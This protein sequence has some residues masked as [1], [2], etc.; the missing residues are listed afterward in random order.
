M[1]DGSKPP[2]NKRKRDNGKDTLWI[3]DDTLPTDSSEDTKK[4]TILLNIHISGKSDEDDEDEDEDDD[5]DDDHEDD[6]HDEDE[7]DD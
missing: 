7:D 6:D 1:D 5:H 2:P 4:P 3:N